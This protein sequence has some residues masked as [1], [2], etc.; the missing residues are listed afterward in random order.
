MSM[1]IANVSKADPCDLE[2][3][4]VGDVMTDEMAITKKKHHERTNVDK[5]E[6]V[7]TQNEYLYFF[8][9][10][11][12]NS[13]GTMNGGWGGIFLRCICGCLTEKQVCL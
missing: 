4:A 5:T 12:F 1:Q 8:A 10:T 11:S 7:I 13:I 2:L 6:L 3:V 9:I